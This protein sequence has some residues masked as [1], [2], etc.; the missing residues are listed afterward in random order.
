MLCGDQR[1][2]GQSE[3]LAALQSK[4]AGQV[5][6]IFADDLVVSEFSLINLNGFDVNSHSDHF[7]HKKNRPVDQAVSRL[8]SHE[9]LVPLVVLFNVLVGKALSPAR[10]S[11]ARP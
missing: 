5:R 7:A 9:G 2:V 8:R 4:V 1:H 3:K 6:E 11:T 10:T